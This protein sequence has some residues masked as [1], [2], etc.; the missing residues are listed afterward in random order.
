MD[1][2]TFRAAIAAEA[3]TWLKTPYHPSG[4]L[5]GVGVNCAQLLY[6]VAKG[7]GVLP[8]DAPLPRWYTP[9]LATHSREE[10]LIAYV[11]SYGAH[12]IPE[13]EAKIGDIVLYRSGQAHGH[14]AILLDPPRIIHALSPRGCQYGSIDGGKLA[15]YSRRYFTLW[16]SEE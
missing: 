14:A 15:A 3:V 11:L 8:D 10:R 7:A 1:E 5:K 12:E 2:Q 16:K 4:A 6:G 13:S 9:Q